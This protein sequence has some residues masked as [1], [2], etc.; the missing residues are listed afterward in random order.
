VFLN[1]DTQVTPGWLG[2]L[3]QPLTREASVVAVQ[4]KLLH[5]DGKLQCAGVVFSAHS[6][7]GYP[8]YGG[9]A[10]DAGWV[11]RPRDVQAVTAAC[12]AVRAEDFTRVGGF[13]TGFLN[14][15]EDVDLCLRLIGLGGTSVP[16]RV[17]RYEP[18]SC[19][20]H[21]ESR[22]PGRHTHLRENRRAFLQRWQGRIGADDLAHYEAD[23]FEVVRYVQDNPENVRLGISVSR[24]LLRKRPP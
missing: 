22:T 7:L 19:V 18:Q 8:L 17:C 15:Q 24:P 20:V 10:G 6:G 1:N 11:N 3:V 16:R 5:P 14:G 13:D 23:G 9:V 2:A 12:M 21:H 4:P